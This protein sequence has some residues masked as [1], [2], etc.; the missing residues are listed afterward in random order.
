MIIEISFNLTDSVILPLPK[1][2]A[3][4]EV[5]VS[6][7][8]N[9]LRLFILGSPFA[10]WTAGDKRE[11]SYQLISDTCLLLIV[12]GKRETPLEDDS[13]TVNENPALNLSPNVFC[14]HSSSGDCGS[15]GVNVDTSC[16]CT[17]SGYISKLQSC[18]NLAHV[19]A[20]LWS[21]CSNP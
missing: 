10:P 11:C 5:C 1:V 16:S 20:L 18:N 6:I 7:P 15:L 12:H 14:P 21:V 19:L 17:H 2:L 8:K 9:I 3:Y 4:A 13:E